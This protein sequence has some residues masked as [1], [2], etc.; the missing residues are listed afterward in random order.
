M[1]L[2]KTTDNADSR[3]SAAQG[4]KNKPEHQRLPNTW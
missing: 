2:S 4:T 1:S 3:L